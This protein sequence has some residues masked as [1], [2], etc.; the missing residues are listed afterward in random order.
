MCC[1][2]AAV[3]PTA[4]SRAKIYSCA[5]QLQVMA[6]PDFDTAEKNS[7]F[8][9]AHMEWGDHHQHICCSFWWM[10]AMIMPQ[11]PAHSIWTH[12]FLICHPKVT[13]HSLAEAMGVKKWQQSIK[14]PLLG[15]KN[16]R[17]GKKEWCH[18]RKKKEKTR[19]QDS[20]LC[21]QGQ[22]YNSNR[23][24]FH[25]AIE[26]QMTLRPQGTGL[27]SRSCAVFISHSETASWLCSCSKS[28][29]KRMTLALM[30]P[31][32]ENYCWNKKRWKTEKI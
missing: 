3:Q 20:I 32:H 5:I 9:N 8:M 19:T 17:F 14:F 1:P 22:K 23:N 10:P 24:L 27:K 31:T 15:R 25:K 29:Y 13:A 28:Y 16:W 6:N 30:S 11:T 2:T 21:L 18:G 26:I 7:H 12:P 4:G